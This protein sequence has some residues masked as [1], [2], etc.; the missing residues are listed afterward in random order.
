MMRN[1]NGD[2]LDVTLLKA[3]PAYQNNESV[4]RLL[5]GSWFVQTIGT[6]AEVLD[7]KLL[8]LKSTLDE[9]RGYANT[10]EELTVEF[11]GATMTGVIIGQPAPEIQKPGADPLYLVNF[12]M[13][14]TS[15]V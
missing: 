8:C 4:A 15:N 14:V 1:A 9:L 2:I 6:A 3:E 12:E 10:K 11:W 13:A 7:V 5:N